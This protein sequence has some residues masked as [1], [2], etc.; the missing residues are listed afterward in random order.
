MRLSVKRL[1]RLPAYLTTEGITWG[2]MWCV[3]HLYFHTLLKVTPSRRLRTDQ[4]QALP[5]SGFLGADPKLLLELVESTCVDTGV[6]CMRGR[7]GEGK[8]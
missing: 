3:S 5:H 7:M 1:W 6:D 4:E 8:K 2:R